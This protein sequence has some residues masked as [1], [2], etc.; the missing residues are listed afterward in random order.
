MNWL[1]QEEIKRRAEISDEEALNVSIEEWEGKCEAVKNEECARLGSVYCGLCQRHNSS[2]CGG[3]GC[4]NCG[5]HTEG[6]GNCCQ[7][8][9]NFCKDK[10]SP[11][12]QAMLNRLYL[13]RGKRYGKEP[14]K[15]CKKEKPK[16]L[17]R[18]DYG[19]NGRQYWIKICDEVYCLGSGRKDVSAFPDSHFAPNQTGNLLDDLERNSKDL[20][21]FTHDRTTYTLKDDGCVDTQHE[22]EDRWILNEPEKTHQLLGQMLAFAKRKAKKDC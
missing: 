7:E 2:Q 22:G 20:K 12:A 8:Y 15:E 16:E 9:V 1:S 14:K 5:I 21:E 10:T 3:D 11:N 6:I 19:T 18:W 13:E 17:R 4:G